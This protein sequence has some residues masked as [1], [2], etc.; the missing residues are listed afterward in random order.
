MN[1]VEPGKF[2]I[3]AGT[4]IIIVG[5]LFVLSDKIPLGRLPG[6]VQIGSGRFKVY[7]PVATSVLLSLALTIIINFFTRK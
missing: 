1:W 2:L 4:V 3:I 7:I 6:D 5:F